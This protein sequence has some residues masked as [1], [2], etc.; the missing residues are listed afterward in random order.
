MIMEG[1]GMSYNQL[2]KKYGEKTVGNARDLW[3]SNSGLRVK[4]VLA[5]SSD[6]KTKGCAAMFHRGLEMIIKGDVA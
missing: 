2:C 3:Y 1:M 4:A 5:V 6:G